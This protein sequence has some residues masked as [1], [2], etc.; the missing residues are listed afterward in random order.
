MHTPVH[1]GLAPVRWRQVW[2]FLL[3]ATAMGLLAGSIA[4]LLLSVIRW[5][6]APVAIEVVIA[7]LAAAPVVGLVVGVLCRPGWHAAAR[8]VDQCYELKDRSSTALAFAAKPTPTVFHELQVEDAAQHLSGIDPARVVP[9]RVPR[10][11][12]LALAVLTVAVLGLMISPLGSSNVQAGPAQPIPEIVA[13][14]DRIA[15]RLQAF[16]ELAKQEQN[17]ELDKL[18]K[19]L[20]QLV[21]EM[22]QPGVDEREALA[23]LS[24]MQA[25]L[26]AEQAQYNTGLVDG[27]L[28]ALGEAMTA[29]EA[30]EGA[31]KALQEGKYDKAAQELEKLEEPPTDRK[32][33]K[34]LEEKLKQVS[35]QMG[36][37]GLGQMGDAVAEMAEGVKGGKGKF[38]KSAKQL[39]NAVKKQDRRR[40]INNLLAAEI[41]RLS[42]SKCNCNMNGGPLG[43][44][45]ERSTSPSSNWGRA[46]SGNQLGDR[47]N[48]LSQRQMEHITGMP[49]D[50]GESEVETTHSAEGRQQA[51]RGYKDVYKEYRKLSEAVLE[52]EPIPLGHRQTIRKYFELI[53]PQSE[54]DTKYSGTGG[55]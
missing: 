22:K 16:E 30:T 44:R 45:P 26:A 20:K 19:E 1:A 12:P 34:A 37:V 29:A 43:K 40:R 41:D 18:V 14:A 39:A 9:L 35:K 17:P 23:K 50:E 27:Q 51:R 21:E 15:E 4:G 6:G 25:A 48:L 55:Q 32:E 13:E 2:L 3:K 49:G 11:V 24:E 38:Q 42:E 10:I 36:D 8:A 31:G 52:N 5:L 53:R 54:S 7:S 28:Q 33:A 47:T 46:T